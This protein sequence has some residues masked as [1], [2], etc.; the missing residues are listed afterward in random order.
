MM[1]NIKI[2]AIIGIV[3]IVALILAK[4][5]GVT[6]YKDG[7]SLLANGKDKVAWMELAE[8]GDCGGGV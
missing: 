4:S 3:V 8:S 2:A 5:V 6:F 7:L 1:K